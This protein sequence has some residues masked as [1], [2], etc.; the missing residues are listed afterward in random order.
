MKIYNADENHENASFGDVIIGEL[1]K[2]DGLDKNRYENIDSAFV[3]DKSGNLLQLQIVAPLEDKRYIY[4]AAITKRMDKNTLK[5][6]LKTTIVDNSDLFFSFQ[7]DGKGDKETMKHFIVA[8]HPDI[9]KKEIELRP[10]LTFLEIGA[11]M[12][13][14][15][16]L[17]RRKDDGCLYARR[18][19]AERDEHSGKLHGFV[20]P[21][22]TSTYRK[23]PMRVPE[24]P[25][26]FRRSSSKGVVQSIKE[27]VAPVPVPVPV[28]PAPVPQVQ[29]SC[30]LNP[31]TN[32]CVSR[33]GS[34][35]KKLKKPLK[36]CPNF[37]KNPNTGHCRKNK[38]IEPKVHRKVPVAVPAP[39]QPKKTIHRKKTA[40]AAQ[41]HRK[42]PATECV[43]NPKTNRCVS[44][45]SAIVKTLKKPLRP[46]P[47]HRKDPKT[48]FCRS[49]AKKL[50]KHQKKQMT[51]TQLLARCYALGHRGISKYTKAQLVNLC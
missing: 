45:D 16:A 17:I 7:L 37:V 49:T 30:V 44:I 47:L 11:N 32:K 4:P 18:F 36:P 51:R 19:E 15:L 41:A 22:G 24:V 9:S 39:K 42:V 48:G 35:A 14:F 50:T 8:V 26:T 43:W 28:T 21:D 20:S 1:H 13:Y 38:I 33:D 10:D 40:A 6:A 12:D 34:V 29:T 46:C 3:V 2:I 5:N 23:M 31:K 25:K 27:V